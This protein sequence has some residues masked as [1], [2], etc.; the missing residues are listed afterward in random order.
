LDSEKSGKYTD[1]HMRFGN[2]TYKMFMAG[3]FVMV[4]MEAEINS[5]IRK[6]KSWFYKIIS[7][8]AL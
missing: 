4:P 5:N 7:K 6:K 8:Y 2:N 3:A 1:K